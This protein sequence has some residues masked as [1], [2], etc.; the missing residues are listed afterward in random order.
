MVN[1]SLLQ[2]KDDTA[3]PPVTLPDSFIALKSTST[4]SKLFLQVVAQFLGDK[5]RGTLGELRGQA[6]AEVADFLDEVRKPI[7]VIVPIAAAD[8]PPC[9]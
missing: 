5:K 6:A 7:V 1:I 3:S 8:R 2:S 9:S 4:T